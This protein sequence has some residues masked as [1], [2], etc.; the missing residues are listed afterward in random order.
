MK[1]TAFQVKRFVADNMASA[2]QMVKNEL[3]QDAV[4]LSNE[5][6]N[7]KI[8]VLAA[9]NEMGD[10]VKQ[11]A[12]DPTQHANQTAS[13]LLQLKKEKENI[14]EDFDIDNSPLL[15]EKNRFLY[16]V[17]LSLIILLIILKIVK[18]YP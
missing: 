12:H 2:F 15:R 9:P 17:L 3:G 14:M 4:I 5:E 6:V 7:G 10:E 11:P 18:P 13:A 1:N 8:Q 16:K